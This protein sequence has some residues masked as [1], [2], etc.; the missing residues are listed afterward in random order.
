MLN[1]DVCRACINARSDI[2]LSRDEQKWLVGGSDQHDSNLKLRGW[3]G[4]D[5]FNWERAFV[6]CR[7]LPAENRKINEQPPKW[8]AYVAEH[9][10]CG[11]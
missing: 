5:E 10:I 4:R 11:G 9:L 7:H 1:K 2:P 8:C 3:N 6:R